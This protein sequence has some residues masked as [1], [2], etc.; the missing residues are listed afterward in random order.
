VSPGPAA[1]EVCNGLDDDCDGFVDER[2]ECGGP[3]GD[4]AENAASTWT[5]ADLLTVPQPFPLCSTT[6]RNHSTVETSPQFILAGAST[7][8]FNYGTAGST[9]G[10][11]VF[12]GVYPAA[13]NGAWDLTT[14]AYSTIQGIT[15]AAGYNVPSGV[16][17]ARAL[18]VV[19]LC[20]PAGY[21][22]YAPVSQSMGNQYW[23]RSFVPIGGNAAWSVTDGGTFDLSHVSFVEFYFQPLRNNVAGQIVVWLDDV[24]FY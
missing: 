20:S 9:N 1:R 2:P 19:V 3:S 23:I 12:T 10:N 14:S 8:R 21:R 16:S 22:L 6:E 24:K 7:A 15:F 11:A 17:W 13:R 4:F 18:P 5:T